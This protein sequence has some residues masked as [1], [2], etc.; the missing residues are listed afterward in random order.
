VSRE[1]TTDFRRS[2][3]QLERLFTGDQPAEAGSYIFVPEPGRAY[4]RGTAV[5]SLDIATVRT[6][7]GLWVPATAATGPAPIDLIKTYLVASEVFGGTYGLS[8]A[9]DWLSRA[10]RDMVLIECA[11]LLAEREKV[12]ANWHDL[13]VDLSRR[14]FQEPH[15][16]KVVNLLGDDRHLLSSQGLLVLA[17]AALQVCPAVGDR[18]VSFA[19][20]AVLAFQEV[21][22]RD[23]DTAVGA[24]A[25]SPA[26]SLFREI[27]QSQ[28][29]YGE[30]YEGSLMTHFQ[31]R[32]RELP[33]AMT[34]ER[35][36]VDLE[37]T[38]GDATG[39]PLEDFL[40]IGLALWAR[41]MQHPGQAITFGTL[42]NFRGGPA[43]IE[44]VASLIAGEPTA[45]GTALADQERRFG[46]RWS[47]DALRHFPVVR[48]SSES[49]L[50]LSPRLLFERIYGWLPIFDLE[51]SLRSRGDSKAA[52]RAK[53]FFRRV[54]ERQALDSL[55]ACA[56]EGGLARRFYSE[57][58]LK[59]AYG[60]RT[61][62]AA[63]DCGSAWV[64]A[65][66]STAQLK[67]ESVV[68]GDPA[69]LEKD[70]DR[71][72]YT[73]ARQLDATVCALQAD[74]SRLT[75]AE[76]VVGRRIVPLL[77]VTEGFPVNPN[78]TLAIERKLKDEGLLQGGL[79]AP[80]RIV[81]QEEL[82]MIESVV[83]SGGGLLDL[84]DAYNG[85][86][87]RAAGFKEWLL[88]ERRL[89]PS[90]PSRLE[91]AF[92]ASWEPAVRAF[93][94]ADDGDEGGRPGGL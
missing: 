51:T 93:G 33:A 61:A 35:Q 80:I 4:V 78:S 23:D 75:S 57:A 81:D 34:S 19:V 31:L 55:R 47:F 85:G 90:R 6:P 10:D 68:G 54:C 67:R 72:V 32:W 21:L 13:D 18:S 38:F 74:E 56:V 52:E 92:A 11:G 64:V 15:S 3:R 53:H 44:A 30:T 7:S 9:L 28:A 12:D 42:A 45:L 43:R 71:A 77:V 8:D 69:E 48:P 62:D 58:D 66:V 36:W 65:E 16:T 2:L 76:P 91:T 82:D 29:F 1:R 60:G 88:L 37:Q 14:I 84:L 26:H 41:S 40:A 24:D 59:M 63:I 5:R 27:V 87:L 50:V 20:P 83:E 46:F 73:K 79:I 70:L 86:R 17:K 89:Q 39:V 25:G 22:G 94:G 49:F